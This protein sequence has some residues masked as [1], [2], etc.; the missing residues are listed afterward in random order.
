MLVATLISAYTAASRDG[1]C[2][3]G[4]CAFGRQ[5]RESL[6]RHRQLDRSRRP[7]AAFWMRSWLH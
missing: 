6:S 3:G 1:F 5:F 7:M 2:P 4:A